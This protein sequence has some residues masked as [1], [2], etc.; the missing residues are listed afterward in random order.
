MGE[1]NVLPGGVEVKNL[2]GNAGDKGS[3]PG[4][5]ASPGEG[6]GSSLP[7]LFSPGKSHGQRRLVGYSL[8]GWAT[9]HTCTVCSQEDRKGRKQQPSPCNPPR[10]TSQGCSRAVPHGEDPAGG[11]LGRTAE[12]KEGERSGASGAGLGE[13]GWESQGTSHR[14]FPFNLLKNI[15]L[16]IQ[17]CWASVAARGIFHCSSWTL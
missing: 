8:W 7:P 2:P 3:I 5:G 13:K 12:R 16:F 9:E 15:Y 10:L 11:P 4:S 14:V 1:Y 17:L 6:T